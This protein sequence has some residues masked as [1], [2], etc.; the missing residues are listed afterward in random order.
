MHVAPG[1]GRGERVAV[2]VSNADDAE[3]CS[4]ALAQAGICNATHTDADAFSAALNHDTDVV[5]ITAEAMSGAAGEAL[6]GFL[7]AQ[8][9]WSSLPVVLLC[10][11]MP[12]ST[13]EAAR[14]CSLL[15][16][17]SVLESPI[18]ITSFIS[19]VQMALYERRQ[20]FRIRDLLEE[21]AAQIRQRDE[22]MA[23][24]G[25]EL[26]NPLAAISTCAEVLQLAPPDSEHCASC[27]DIVQEQAAN[28]KRMLDD[29]LDISR[30]ARDKLTVRRDYVDLVQVLRQCIDQVTSEIRASQQIL[31]VELPQQ[32]LPLLGDTTRLQQV[33]VNLLQNASRYSQEGSRIVLS[34]QRGNGQVEVRVRDEG[35]GMSAE[36]LAN[37]F[38]PFYQGDSTSA[39]HGQRGLGLGLSLAARLVNLHGGIIRAHSEGPGCGSEFVV[40]LPLH[41]AQSVEAERGDA[42]NASELEAQRILLIDDNQQLA[43]GLKTLLEDRGHDVRLA[44]DGHAGLEAARSWLPDVV[45]IDIGL[46]GID[47]YEV[48]ASPAPPAGA[49]TCAAHRADRLWQYRRPAAGRRGGLRLSPGQADECRRTGSRYPRLRIAAALTG[50]AG[51]PR[52]ARGAGGF[53]VVVITSMRGLSGSDRH[54]GESRRGTV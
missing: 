1:A 53:V 17:V 14:D 48:G 43:L 32:P 37:V 21:R 25:H 13:R 36:T 34:T 6:T 40:T 3:L 52:A 11:A 41:S 28:M 46:P 7:Q 10:R 44:H 4:R 54:S 19:T 9:D 35:Q 12:D 47:G 50:G 15:G 18:R 8:P 30:L 39:L 5:V 31:Q 49:E 20:Q 38:E 45:V 42:G 26:R 22:F 24:L 2:L 27:K 16:R 33:M 51:M 29:L 23:L